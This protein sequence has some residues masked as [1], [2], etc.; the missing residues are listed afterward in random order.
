MNL[1]P[2]TLLFFTIPNLFALKQIAIENSED[3][4]YYCWSFNSFPEKI[5]GTIVN[6]HN[7]TCEPTFN[8]EK[9]D[10]V[11]VSNSIKCRKDYNPIILSF[12]VTSK[13]NLTEI[14]KSDEKSIWCSPNYSFKNGK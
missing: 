11:Y 10:N 12:K 8:S 5:T 1:H 4:T 13:E 6:L 2:L 14:L 3:V 7:D 9:N